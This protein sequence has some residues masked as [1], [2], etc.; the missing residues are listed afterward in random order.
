MSFSSGSFYTQ[1]T[2][3][4]S[5]VE[6]PQCRRILSGLRLYEWERKSQGQKRLHPPMARLITLRDS[7]SA[8]D[9][10]LVQYPRMSAVH[11]SRRRR[12]NNPRK[13]LTGASRLLRW[14]CLRSRYRASENPN[15]SRP[16][17]FHNRHRRNRQWP[18]FSNLILTNGTCG[19]TCSPRSMSGGSCLDT[20]A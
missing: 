19:S 17:F 11:S 8:R 15:A 3:S 12:R 4:K 10:A 7:F 1:S 13:C 5:L 9:S 6:I 2:P 16:G 18:C 14:Y 20:R